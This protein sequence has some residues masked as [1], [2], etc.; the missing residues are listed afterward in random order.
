MK[1][2]SEFTLGLEVAAAGGSVFLCLILGIL[3][4]GHGYTSEEHGV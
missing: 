1:H 2:R 4:L 3:S